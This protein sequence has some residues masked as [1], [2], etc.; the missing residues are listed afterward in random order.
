VAVC[1]LD[2]R[3]GEKA[4]RELQAE[5]GVDR[6]IFIKTDVTNTAELEGNLNALLKKI[7]QTLETLDLFAKLFRSDKC[8]CEFAWRYFD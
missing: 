2:S 3:K 7:R 6:A 4:V 5:Y 8:G 1:D